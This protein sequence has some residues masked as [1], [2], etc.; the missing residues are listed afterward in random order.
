MLC[1]CQKPEENTMKHISCAGFVL[2]IILNG[3]VTQRAGIASVQNAVYVLES[4][5][6]LPAGRLF[7][8][9]DYC[10]FNAER[11]ADDSGL[12]K[13]LAK[14]DAR[15]ELHFF[16]RTAELKLES[17]SGDTGAAFLEYQKHYASRFFFVEGKNSVELTLDLIA[18]DEETRTSIEAMPAAEQD[19]VL[20]S[21]FDKSKDI[22]IEPDEEDKVINYWRR[23]R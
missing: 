22:L 5:K 14:A 7:S 1:P 23:V 19:A 20:K 15:L 21:V 3:C 6:D 4:V 13:T 11:G 18:L 12:D 16:D 2:L 17:A 9:R 8:F 10:A